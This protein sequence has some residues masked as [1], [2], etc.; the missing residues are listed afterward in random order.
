M[1]QRPPL[2]YEPVSPRPA[3]RAV[4]SVLVGIVFAIIVLA[5]LVDGWPGLPARPSAHRA[6]C[7]NN[8]RQIGLACSMYANDFGHVF[9]D[10]LHLLMTS[11]SLAAEVFVCPSSTDSVAT[12]TPGAAG[13][14]FGRARALLLHLRGR[15]P[16][17][18]RAPPSASSPGRT[19]PITRWL[20]PTSSTPTPTSL[21][22]R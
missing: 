2:G 9:P 4:S 1:A 5:L 17:Q 13:G 8:L 19:P 10:S 18:I 7:S 11:E 22:S 20:E 16:W 21:S 14:G 3:P 15:A 12:G 6:K